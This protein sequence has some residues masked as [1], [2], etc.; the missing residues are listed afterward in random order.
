MLSIDALETEK[1]RYNRRR[2]I[3]YAALERADRKNLTNYIILR[4]VFEVRQ[5][6]ITRL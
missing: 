2:V 3:N 6:F 5:L 1:K 4:A